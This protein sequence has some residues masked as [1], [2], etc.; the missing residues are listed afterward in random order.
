MVDEMV[1][2]VGGFPST[3][4]NNWQGICANTLGGRETLGDQIKLFY[5]RERLRRGPRSFRSERADAILSRAMTPVDAMA[6]IVAPGSMNSRGTFGR[7]IVQ[8]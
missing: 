2:T 4:R 8:P 3:G 7:T 5:A 1:Q 6:A